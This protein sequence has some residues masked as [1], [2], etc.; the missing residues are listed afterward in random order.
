M[1]TLLFRSLLFSTS[2]HSQ[3]RAWVRT[4]SRLEN[5]VLRPTP[6]TPSGV[7]V[8]TGGGVTVGEKGRDSPPVGTRSSRVKYDKLGLCNGEETRRHRMR[9]PS[10]PGTTPMSPPVPPDSSVPSVRSS[11]EW[12]VGNQRRRRRR[13]L[14]Y[15]SPSWYAAY[16]EAGCRKSP[17]R[18]LSKNSRGTRLPRDL[19]RVPSNH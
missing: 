17:P 11:R 1:S 14:G 7:G 6:V 18:T 12:E 2:R 13:N 9:L 8:D 3:S 5:R 4:D 19:P 15:T 10:S 16:R